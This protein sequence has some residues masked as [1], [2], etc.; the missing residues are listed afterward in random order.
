M[1]LLDDASLVDQT[2]DGVGEALSVLWTRYYASAYNYARVYLADDPDAIVS[3]AYATIWRAIQ[4]GQ[5]PDG[6]FRAYLYAIIRTV[7][8]DRQ[9]NSEGASPKVPSTMGYM[10]DPTPERNAVAR[11]FYG[12]GQRY[13]EVLWLSTADGFNTNEIAEAL[14]VQPPYMSVLAM[15]A[16]GAFLKLWRQESGAQPG[17]LTDAADLGRH[18]QA[19]VA[20]L[21]EDQVTAQGA[22]WADSSTVIAPPPM[23]AAVATASAAKAVNEAPSGARSGSPLV[24]WI[25]GLAVA[26]VI[27]VVAI[28]YGFIVRSA[29]TNNPPPASSSL[30]P[31]SSTSTTDQPPSSNIV[32]PESTDT[33]NWTTDPT[34]TDTTDIYPTDT[35]TWP[36][37]TSSTAPPPTSS[38]SSTTAGSTTTTVPRPT[39]TTTTSTWTMP[40]PSSTTASVTWTTA[41]EPPQTTTLIP[42]LGTWTPTAWPPI[43]PSSPTSTAST[44][45]STAPTPT[46]IWPASTK[47][48]YGW[49]DS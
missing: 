1:A 11:C 27:G 23:P 48:V 33:Y 40:K 31:P 44:T 26:L 7:A 29:S 19:G 9:L 2:R 12:L 41:T 38:T 46:A 20:G 24:A 8:A 39:S 16:K 3:D 47:T 45:N 5:M 32:P 6:N 13:R 25:I 21:A 22:G 42:T 28:S 35:A 15:R 36:L 37:D 34:D 4:N 14:G 10:L 30:T 17:E 49:G 18:L 43:P